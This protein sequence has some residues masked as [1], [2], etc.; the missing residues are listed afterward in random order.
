LTSLGGASFLA[1]M[2]QRRQPAYANSKPEESF[3]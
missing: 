1:R 3:I 2:Q